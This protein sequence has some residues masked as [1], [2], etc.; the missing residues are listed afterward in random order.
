L[1][2]DGYGGAFEQ[3]AP[4]DTTVNGQNILG[5]W[6]H[7]F[8]LYSDLTVQLYWDR[9]WR[10]VPNQYA[11]NLN[12]FDMDVQHTFP[13]GSRQ[14]VT[15]GGGYRLYNDVFENTPALAL[16]PDRRNLQLFSAFVQDEI[17]LV[18]N[19]LKLTIGTKLE[20]N[21][22]SGFEVQPSGRLAWTP[23]QRQTIWAAVSRA[24]RTP[25]RVDT[26][27]FFP[28]TAPFTIAGGS[29]FDSEKLAAY[30]IGYKARVLTNLS[31]SVSTFYNDYTD[32]RSL[33]TNET[34]NGA[35]VIGNN[36]LA[37]TWGVEL[38]LQWEATEFWRLRGG[39]TY[40]G[41]A[42]EIRPGGSDLNQGRAEGNDPEHQVVLQSMLDLPA[43]LQFDV[44]VRY[45]DQLP[46]PNVPSYWGLDIRLGWTSIKNLDFS[47]VG[48][49]LLDSQHP[50][51]GAPATR[52]EIPRSVFGK[53]TWRF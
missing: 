13:L 53:V 36:N 22:F 47:I 24:V 43:N 23:D 44:V 20:H 33:S 37:Q 4:G 46:M 40:L 42:T 38:G 12:T 3:P 29:D 8:G 18:Q 6:N 9:T 48:Q 5:R 34:S 19:R 52:Q 27:L 35:F 7:S 16:I 17:S 21:D 2:G 11:E 32:I 31:A 25:S 39:Y 41:K 50:E 49:N 26:D 51:F 30:E 28:G 1:Q 10:R 14:Q 15:W 45:V